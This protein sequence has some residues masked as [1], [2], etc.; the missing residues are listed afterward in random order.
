[1]IDYAFGF[2]WSSNDE[3]LVTLTLFDYDPKNLASE[4][5]ETKTFEIGSQE[6]NYQFVLVEEGLGRIFYLDNSGE[7]Q[8]IEISK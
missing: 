2:V 7:L 1:M 4:V 3:N 6:D 5:K 8:I